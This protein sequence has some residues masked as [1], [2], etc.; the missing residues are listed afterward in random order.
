M[1]STTCPS[2]SNRA[3]LDWTVLTAAKTTN[4]GDTFT[5]ASGSLTLA[6]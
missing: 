4:A 2:R 6:M 1:G 3:D 5:I